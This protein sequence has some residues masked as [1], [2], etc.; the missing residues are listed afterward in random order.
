MREENPK[1]K[2]REERKGGTGS[3]VYFRFKRRVETVCNIY[4]R[5]PTD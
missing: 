2:K 4:I 3:D 1:G 5:R